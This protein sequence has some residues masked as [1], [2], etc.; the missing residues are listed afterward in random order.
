MR[1]TSSPFSVISN[2][3]PASHNGHVRYATRVPSGAGASWLAVSWNTGFGTDAMLPPMRQLFPVPLDSVDPAAAYHAD[4]RDGSPWVLVNMI[5]SVD[6]AT[7]VQG[8]SGAMGGPGDKRVFGA[9]RA[10]ADVILVGAGTVRAENYGPVPAPTRL[11][12]V[13]AALDLAPTARVFTGGARPIIVTHE[14]APADRRAALAGVAEVLTFGDDRVDVRAALD[15]FAAD[16]ARVV[17]CEG[18]PS[19]NGQLVAE[20]LVDEQCLT[21]APLL[22]S[23]DSA[24]LAHGAN[25]AAPERLT[26]QRVLEEDG[27]LFLRY[28]RAPRN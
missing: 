13:S 28:V 20:D 22:V 15:A 6:G 1:W 9:I 2:P 19:L 8:R 3:H 5:A 7:A 17:V 26:L 12:I 14:R 11:A 21:V 18:G 24:R 27:Y 10:V 16:G 4:V 25:P 23:G